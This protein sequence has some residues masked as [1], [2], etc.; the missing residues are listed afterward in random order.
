MRPAASVPFQTLR[1]L[2]F[3]QT[4]EGPN[5]GNVVLWQQTD[6]TLT[7][8]A[9]PKELPDPS[10]SAES[11]RVAR[12]IWAL[13]EGYATFKDSDPEFAAFLKDRLHLS[14]DSINRQSLSRYGQFDVADGVQVPAWLIAG[15]ADASAE[16]VLGLAAYSTVASDDTRATTALPHSLN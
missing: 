13:G 10:D 2:T 14:L 7:P 16:A 11:Y 4:S 6:G 5:A 3:L 12:T 9:I 15:G 1:S 8:S